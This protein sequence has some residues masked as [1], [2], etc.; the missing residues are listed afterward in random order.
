MD[1][2][3]YENLFCKISIWAYHFYY[4]RALKEMNGDGEDTKELAFQNT[5]DT[6][7]SIGMVCARVNDKELTVFVLDSEA[8][9]LINTKTGK[10]EFFE[11]IKDKVEKE[12]GLKMLVKYFDVNDP[13]E[14]YLPRENVYSYTKPFILSNHSIVS[15]GVLTWES[16]FDLD[17][18]NNDSL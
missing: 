15:D 8:F 1:K 10:L 4:L 14:K 2:K 17:E 13:V 9:Y 5:Y 18:V 3:E 6:L 11:F 7:S 12:F 16:A